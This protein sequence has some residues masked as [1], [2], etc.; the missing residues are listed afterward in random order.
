MIAS[1]GIAP[2]RE[3]EVYG[4]FHLPPAGG[5]GSQDSIHTRYGHFIYW[6]IQYNSNTINLH[7]IVFNLLDNANAAV[8]SEDH[9]PP[10]PA[11]CLLFP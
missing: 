8:A 9:R 2:R 5:A 3:A 11:R 4:I 1:Q 6:R 7:I 10:V